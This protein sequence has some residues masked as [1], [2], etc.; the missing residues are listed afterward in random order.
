VIDGASEEEVES[1]LGEGLGWAPT[2]L[3]L[4]LD[5]IMMHIDMLPTRRR[6]KDPHSEP[7]V[8]CFL[9]AWGQNRSRAVKHIVGQSLVGSE[10][11][12]EII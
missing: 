9:C 5:L 7:F 1:W 11:V 3:N 8:V 6:S 4:I 2:R 12:V 10:Y